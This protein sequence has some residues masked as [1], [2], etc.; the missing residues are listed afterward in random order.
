M[1]NASRPGLTRCWKPHHIPVEGISFIPYSRYVS[2]LHTYYAPW[3]LDIVGERIQCGPDFVQLS[4]AQRPQQM[5]AC[6]PLLIAE[7]DAGKTLI[8]QLA[9]A[10][11]PARWQT[12][13]AELKQAM[14][15][16][17]TWDAQRLQAINAKN[18][19][20]YVLVVQQGESVGVMFCDPID[21][22]N[23]FLFSRKRRSYRFQLLGGRVL[24]EARRVVNC[25]SRNSQARAEYPQFR[26]DYWARL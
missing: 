3:G 12:E 18:V 16:A 25:T 5:Q 9:T 13:H 24:D 6:R 20:Q 4:P 21:K 7:I 19:N 14:Q 17:D 11:P 10:Q 1:T 15:A 26:L 8:A 22:F 23:A 2:L